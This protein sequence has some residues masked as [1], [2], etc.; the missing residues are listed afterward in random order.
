[1]LLNCTALYLRYRI[2]RMHAQS[3]A[4]RGLWGRL[5]SLGLL[6]QISSCHPC[7]YSDR[8]QYKVKQLG[9]WRGGVAAGG[10]PENHLEFGFILAWTG[11][12]TGGAHRR[13]SGL[14]GKVRRTM[15]AISPLMRGKA[16]ISRSLLGQAIIRNFSSLLRGDHL[17]IPGTGLSKGTKMTFTYAGA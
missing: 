12:Q 15:V 7:L 5:P 6:F 11:R 16:A 17:H 8:V 4:I 9:R 13:F 2:I 1:M 14:I 10:P 3:P